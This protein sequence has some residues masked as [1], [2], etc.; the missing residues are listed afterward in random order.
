MLDAEALDVLAICSPMGNHRQALAAASAAGVHVLCEKPLHWDARC[1]T[2]GAAL[3]DEVRAL[4]EGYAARGR[5]LALN[6]QWPTTLPA[7]HRLH[8]RTQGGG[9][10]RFEMLMSPRGGSGAGPAPAERLVVD[11]APHA[12]SMLRALVGGGRVL[13]AR[14]S[15]PADV[16][17]GRGA[18]DLSFRWGHAGGATDVVLRLRQCPEQ[19]RPA[20]YAVDGAWVERRVSQPGYVMSLVA[21]DGRSEPLRDPLDVLVAGF[22]AD[23]AAGRLPD[24]EALVESMAALRDLVACTEGPEDSP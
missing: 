20:G 10:Q 24:V 8:G 12:L 21:P 5:L 17:P 4:A 22:V 19:P 11:A 6:T 18:L 7:Y 9:V 14:A 16:E 15:R 3:E 13:D 23:V 2:A 1:R